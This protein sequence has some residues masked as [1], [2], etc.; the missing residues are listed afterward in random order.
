MALKKDELTHVLEMKRLELEEETK[1][2]EFQLQEKELDTSR[3]SSKE[4]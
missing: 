3:F 1:R 2:A 4:H